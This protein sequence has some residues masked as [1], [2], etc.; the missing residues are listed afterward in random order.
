MIQ[1]GLKDFSVSRARVKWGIPVPEQP[2][3]VLYVWVDALSQLHHRAGLRRRRA[4]LPPLLGGRR[5]A[6][7]P[8]RQG[9][10]PLPLPVLAGDAARGRRAGADAAR[11]RQGFI[12]QERPQA[13][14]DDRQRDRPGGARRAARARRRPLLPAARG[15]LRPGLGLHRRGLRRALQRRPR[16]RPRQPRVAR[17]HD[18]GALLR[19][20]G[21]AARRPGTARRSRVLRPRARSCAAP[22]EHR[23][24]RVVASVLAR[25]EELDFAGALGEIWAARL[26][27]EPG[28]R[29]DRALGRWPRTRR[30]RR[31]LDAFLYR[32]LEGVR[33][34]RRRSPRR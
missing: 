18:G 24:T 33:R 13:Q 34:R 17:A 29:A 28:D 23:W 19:R 4:R 16:E 26:E 2:D 15:E 30:A 20:Q 12:T 27:P 5:R 11:S 3:H 7:A 1:Q 8:D 9:D 32:L 25:Y 21:A 22:V 10:H 6:A 14:Q 31:E